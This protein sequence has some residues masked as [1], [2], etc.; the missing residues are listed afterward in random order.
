MAKLG[1]QSMICFLSVW[2]AMQTREQILRK[3]IVQE[4][5]IYYWKTVQ[6]YSEG[7]NGGGSDVGNSED[8]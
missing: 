7:F 8:L 3:I 2:L 6:E 1:K 4:I 5:W